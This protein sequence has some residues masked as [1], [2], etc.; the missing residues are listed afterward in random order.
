[1]KRLYTIFSL[2]IYTLSVSAQD[3]VFI[4]VDVSKS[5]K[6]A[7]LISAKQTLTEILLGN[8]PN[9]SNV[10][11]G[12]VQDLAQFK[13]K[14]SDKISVVKFVFSFFA[15]CFLIRRELRSTTKHCSFRKS[16]AS[17]PAL[18]PFGIHRQIMPN[19]FAS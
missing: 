5:V 2:I 14:I 10:V 17:R 11:G 3:N 1:M 8:T 7:D 12:S 15:F 6:Q 18:S 9:N 13:I 16:P 4:L 19:W